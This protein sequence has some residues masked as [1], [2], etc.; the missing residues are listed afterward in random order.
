MKKPKHE[1]IIKVC[2]NHGETEFYEY[3]YG[4]CLHLSCKKCTRELRKARYLDPVKEKMDREYSK[5]WAK[6]NQDRL[7]KGLINRKIMLDQRIADLKIRVFE[8]NEREIL[9]ILNLCK[10]KA[11][12]DREKAMAFY[13]K[14]VAFLNSSFNWNKAKSTL[15][16]RTKQLI[17]Q[18]ETVK[19]KS[20]LGLIRSGGTSEY[21]NSYP[22]A[23]EKVKQAVRKE[24]L[25]RTDAI[26]KGFESSQKIETPFK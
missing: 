22:N 6:L 20:K 19:V 23:P 21:V 8:E 7:K 2:K 15:M 10:P 11:E 4:A 1:T 16:N 5:S 26:I 25:E 18:R 9:S 3:T 12:F 17:Y 13:L 24:S 14:E